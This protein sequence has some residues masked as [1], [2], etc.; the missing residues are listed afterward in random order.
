MLY[1]LATSIIWAFSFGLIGNR[2]AGLDPAAIA[3]IR[4]GLSFLVFLPPAC[5]GRPGFPLAVTLMVAGAL[6]FGLMYVLYIASFAHLPSHVVALF[7]ITTPVY[8]VLLASRGRLRRAVWPL[9]AAGLAVLA[10]AIVNWK[11]P[12]ADR[13]WT[14]FALVQASNLCFAAGQLLYRRVMRAPGAIRDHQA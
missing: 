1:L 6:Q 8:V 9:T 3:G 10:A 12:E 5:H 11:R 4:L 14:G 7:T 13:I 2:L